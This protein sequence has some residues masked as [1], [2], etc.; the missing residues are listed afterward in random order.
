[1][2][3]LCQYHTCE[4]GIFSLHIFCVAFPK[5]GDV[6]L[7]SKWLWRGYECTQF[8]ISVNTFS[9]EKTASP[10]LP[11]SSIHPTV[12]ST[13]CLHGSLS[14]SH[15]H[16]IETWREAILSL[17]QSVVFPGKKTSVSLNPFWHCT[18]IFEL[19][20]STQIWF[21]KTK[22]NKTNRKWLVLKLDKNHKKN[23]NRKGSLF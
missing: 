23:I 15:E 17:S 7:T 18:E 8:L 9:A 4:K 1:M 3:W 11:S 22:Q 2:P 12:N 13:S 14:H 20:S 16:Q 6:I 21:S 10:C 5:S 19:L